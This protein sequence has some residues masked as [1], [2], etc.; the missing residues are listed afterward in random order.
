MLDFHD[1][2][3]PDFEPAWGLQGPHAQTLAAAVS[4][5]RDPSTTP[6]AR[7]V[8]LDDGDAVVLHEQTPE[9]WRPGAPAV[10]LVHGLGGCHASPYMRRLAELLAARGAATYRMDLRGAGA[11]AELA[12]GHYHLGRRDDIRAAVAAIG[13]MRPQA[14]C[15]AVGF[16]LGGALVL[17]AAGAGAPEN[18]AAVIAVSPPI[19]PAAC[20]RGLDRGLPRWYSRRLAKV[21]WRDIL[22]RRAVVP[23]MAF[24]HDARE[25]TSIWELD[26]YFT[27]PLAGFE[28]AEDYYTRC[29]CGP[30]LEGTETPTL[31]FTSG[32]DPL[33]PSGVWRQ[34]ARAPAV[35]V[36]ATARGGHVGYLAR[37]GRDPSRRWLDWRILEAVRAVAAATC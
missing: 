9:R 24:P 2:E 22:R 26:E 32:D 23:D 1:L 21:V 29:D 27:A 25:P 5:D 17:S 3:I 6:I 19:H 36:V 28:S 4:F 8:V 34:L 12:R 16:S 13:Q 18:L 14:R 31:I 15:V 7:P 10:L 30:S 33:A 11:G 20:V 35:R 37:R